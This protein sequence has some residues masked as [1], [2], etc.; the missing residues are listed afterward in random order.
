MKLSFEVWM[1]RVN[2]EI[3]KL[4]GMFAADLPDYDYRNEY[5]EGCSPKSTARRAVRN[6]KEF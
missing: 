4:C 2:F 5:D 1:E 6:A 3:E